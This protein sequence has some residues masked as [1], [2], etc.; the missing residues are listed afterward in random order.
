MR[1]PRKVDGLDSLGRRAA[2]LSVTF[3]GED[4]H[5]EGVTREF[6]TLLFRALQQT[7]L[8]LW[9]SVQRDEPGV[10]GSSGEDAGGGGEG[11]DLEGIEAISVDEVVSGFGAANLESSTTNDGVDLLPG[12]AL[13]GASIAA[14]GASTPSIAS[15]VAEELSAM[16]QTE[17]A[18]APN[19]LFP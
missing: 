15:L 3:K 16:T 18:Y 14:T 9:R 5:G 19:G 11:V 4:A 6:Y 1:E 12:S 8:N 7:D 10:L 2:V 17:Y 13:R